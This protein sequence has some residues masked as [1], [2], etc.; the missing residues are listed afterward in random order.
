[1]NLLPKI[2]P[3]KQMPEIPENWK[4]AA[5]MK[6]ELEKA[7]FKDVEA[8]EVHVE[9]TVDKVDPFVDFMLEKMPHMSVLISPRYFS[10]LL[11]IELLGSC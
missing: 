1:M 7:G 11:L 2:R 8:H 10:R 4:T 3:D 5:P 6:A 9:M